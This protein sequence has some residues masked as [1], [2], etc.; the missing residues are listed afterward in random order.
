[1]RAEDINDYNI[2]TDIFLSFEMLEHL[3]DPIHFLKSIADN[4]KCKALVVTIP[5][6]KN[7]RVGLSHIA[8]NRLDK[9][10][11]EGVHI[12]ELSPHDWRLIFQH[13]GWSII[14]DEIYLQYPQRGMM[15]CTKML[16]RHLDYEGFYGAILERNDKW[17]SYYIDW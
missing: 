11:A 13:S 15:R 5:Y 7:S 16:W 17:S 10:N 1:M 2:K 4:T 6:V 12:F 3:M 14:K 8:N 9:I